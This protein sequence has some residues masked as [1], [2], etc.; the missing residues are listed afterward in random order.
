MKST[1]PKNLLSHLIEFGML[2]DEDITKKSSGNYGIDAMKALDLQLEREICK[3]ALDGIKNSL[4]LSLIKV[5]NQIQK[6]E[7]NKMYHRTKEKHLQSILEKGLIPKKKKG[8]TISKEHNSV[9]LTNDINK[10][11][12]TQCGKEWINKHKCIALEINTSDLNVA[13]VKYDATYTISDFEFETSYISPDKIKYSHKL[14]K[15]K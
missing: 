11:I 13:P 2:S 7:E 14:Y 1:K 9:F 5:K 3:T 12:E 8:M 10:I 4:I 6:E 15:N